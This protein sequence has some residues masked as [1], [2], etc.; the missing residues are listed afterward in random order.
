RLTSDAAFNAKLGAAF[1][2]ALFGEQR[3]SYI[4]TFAA[5]NAG[6]KRVQEWIN[7]YGDPLNPAIDPV[8][9]IELIPI[10]ETRHYVQLIME[11]L[12]MYRLRF[13]DRSALLI[14]ADLRRSGS[15]S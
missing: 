4:L 3:G 7:A 11:N 6:G 5:Y 12:E 13:G 10:D 9:W 8:D 2:G 15:G 1:L 14:D